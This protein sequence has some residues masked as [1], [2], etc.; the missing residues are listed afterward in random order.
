MDSSREAAARLAALDALHDDVLR[1]LEDLERRTAAALA[2]CLKTQCLE[3]S[4]PA[5]VPF[6][7]NTPARSAKQRRAA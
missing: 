7:R 4:P 1:R 5:V 3:S 2:E 6:T